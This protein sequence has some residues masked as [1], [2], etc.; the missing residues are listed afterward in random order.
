M[1]F[2]ASVTINPDDKIEAQWLPERPATYAP[3]L[4]YSAKF[5]IV[6]ARCGLFIMTR[7]RA[8]ARALAQEIL[9]ALAESEPASTDPCDIELGA[10]DA[11]APVVAAAGE[12]GETR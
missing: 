8:T 10:N 11:P 3:G 2:Y 5:E 4:T 12:M 9:R 7:D 6:I 1:D